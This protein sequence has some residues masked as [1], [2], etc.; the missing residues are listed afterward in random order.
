MI[1]K[2]IKQFPLVRLVLPLII[3][4]WL[5]DQCNGMPVSWW[6][7]SS[8]LVVWVISVF[9][10]FQHPSY[11]WRF[12][13]GSILITW[14]FL[15][16]AQWMNVRQTT[17]LE[18]QPLALKG[19][20]SACLGETATNYKYEI[21]T[22]VLHYDSG[23][24]HTS[25]KGLLYVKKDSM[26]QTLQL[27]QQILL[28]GSLLA[29]RIPDNPEAFD[30]SAYLIREGYSFRMMT[31]GSNI[32]L[33]NVPD[34]KGLLELFGKWR[35]RL[36]VSF[37]EAGIHND[38][39]AVLKALFLG[40]RTEL[41]PEQKRSFS[42]AGV[43]HLLAVSG[44][45][46]GIIYVLLL[47]LFKP[48]FRKRF[49]LLKTGM[50]LMV[51][52][53]YA[54]LTGFPPSVLRAVIMFSLVEVGQIFK[55]PANIY[56]QLLISI[57]IILLIDPYAIYKAGFWL[58]H[59]AV[60]SIVTFYPFINGLIRFQFPVFQWL[61]S[62]I[63][64]SL[65]AQI[66]T[67]ALA[68]YYFNMFPMYFLLGNV[69]LMPLMAPILLAAICTALFSFGNVKALVELSSAPL[70]HLLSVMIELVQWLEQLPGAFSGYLYLS[71]FDLLCIGVVLLG[72]ITWWYL[73]LKQGIFISMFFCCLL[74]ISISYSSWFQMNAKS[75]IIF[76][77]NGSCVI[78]VVDGKNHNLYMSNLLSDLE[79][80]FTCSGYWAKHFL[81]QPSIQEFTKGIHLITVFSH[82]ALIIHD[83]H[84][85]LNSSSDK[86]MEYIVLSGSPGVK[87]HQLIQT[88]EPK[89]IIIASNNKPW[90]A[91]K[92]QEECQLHGVICHDVSRE[93]AWMRSF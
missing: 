74:L 11:K 57:F 37:E 48:L 86:R 71:G 20:I 13:S 54:L 8:V 68:I 29:L 53:G 24:I 61:W 64:V 69:L 17:V 2:F 30:Y 28:K 58:S 1:K 21:R 50:V 92:W 89:A 90:L 78:D 40:D 9:Y 35:Q 15:V 14:M 27:G 10:F 49:R 16:A 80:E 5:G 65:A 23:Q 46:L 36:A 76:K 33:L 81:K 79:L 43:I 66:G 59:L 62:L 18:D 3:G 26:F 87:I 70:N 47:L 6:L 31:V 60:A 56:N 85:D 44:L 7:I 77:H 88:F 93:G 12:V 75:M 82:Q 63:A 72:L 25:M 52:W 51:L 34:R 73:K 83:V 19:V 22:Q 45:H 4:I 39:L 42:R 32:V 41:E 84:I 38:E 67:F 91:S 55:R